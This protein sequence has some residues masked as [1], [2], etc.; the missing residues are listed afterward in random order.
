[1]QEQQLQIPRNRYRNNAKAVEHGMKSFRLA[2]ESGL[3]DQYVRLAPNDRLVTGDGHQFVNFSSCNYLGLHTHPKIIEG[4]ALMVREQGFMCL[5]ISMVRVCSEVHHRLEEDM[6]DL[7]DASCVVSLSCTSASEGILP[8]L[9][10]GA[11][12]ENER[13]V[14]VFDKHSH[15]SM[16]IAMPMCGDETEVLSCKNNDLNFLEDMCRKHKRVAYVADGAYS[17]GGYTLMKD[18]IAL[19]DRYGLFLYLD[20]SHSLSLCGGKGGGFVRTT[21]N[22]PIND[23]TIIVCSLAKAFGASG[24]V[25]MMG[26][27]PK[28]EEII[29]RM[30]GPFGWSQNLSTANVGAVMASAQLHRSPLLAELQGDLKQRLEQFDQLIATPQAGS[31]FPIRLVE[32]GAEDNA[33]EVSSRLYKRGFYSSAVFFPI[34]AKG[35]AG[36]RVMLRANHRPE[37]V[38]GLVQAIM[39]VRGEVLGEALSG[40]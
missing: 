18:L 34:V 12:T 13:P 33:V 25:V 5:S 11:L 28:R 17:M 23:R 7:Y 38:A 19:Q 27:N 31:A 14:M 39:A 20:D 2:R 15:F 21:M 9:A 36:V 35:K 30:G 22:G 40:S 8:L 3:M 4:A 10:C 37:D 1:M 6:S 24:G 32:I 16:A 26:E 29:R